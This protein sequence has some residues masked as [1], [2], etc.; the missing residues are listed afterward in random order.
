MVNEE[1]QIEPL[2]NT[3]VIRVLEEHNIHFG[4]GPASCTST[5]SNACDLRNLFKAAK[6]KSNDS[7]SK[8]DFEDPVLEEQVSLSI[9]SSQPTISAA[10]KRLIAHGLVHVVRSLGR[11]VNF[12]V[13]SSA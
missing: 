1:V 13:A 2:Q 8:A 6:K 11:T 12:Q 7:L 4:K 3:E 10:K 9:A 5:V